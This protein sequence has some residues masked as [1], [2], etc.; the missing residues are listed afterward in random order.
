M[1]DRDKRPP[2]LQSAALWAMAIVVVYVICYLSYRPAH[3]EVRGRN[4]ARYL[5][6][7]SSLSRSFFGPASRIDAQLTG[8]RI[9][10][11][12]PPERPK[13]R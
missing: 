9:E 8:V 3:I 12:P 7:G 13:R 10:P 6:F 4:G 2:D 11:P 1:G 5:V